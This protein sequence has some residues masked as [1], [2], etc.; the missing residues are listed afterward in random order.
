[1]NA[2]KLSVFENLLWNSIGSFT[3]L[4]CQWLLTLI[5]VRESGNMGNVGDLALAISV[6]NIFYNIACFNVRSYL[7]SDLSGYYKASDYTGFRV[8]S[9]TLSVALCGIYIGVFKYSGEQIVAIFTYMIFKVGEAWVD[10]LHGFEQRQSRM[11]IGGV[12]LF[13]RGLLSVISFYITLKITQNLIWSIAIM[14]LTTYA[15]IVLYDMRKIKQF[16]VVRI[17]IQPATIKKMFF[18]FLPLTVGGFCSSLGANLPRQVL[19]L[20]LGKESLGIYSTVATPAV[21]VQV[22]A[23]YIFNPVLTEFAWLYQQGEKKKFLKLAGKISLVLVLL[24]LVSIVGSIFLGKWGLIL[25]YGKY[26]G[27]YSYLLLPVIIFTCLNAYVW[28]LWNLLIILRALK[29]LLIISFVGLASC[30][31]SMIPMIFF[32]GMNGVSYSLIIYS[33]VMI[34]LMLLLMLKILKN[35]VKTV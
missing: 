34:L 3:Y 27:E 10:L 30:V 5:V 21:I 35:G 2:K 7:I 17:S 8:F 31:V 13:I 15:F 28:F 25:L 26:I 11:D 24:S 18:E 20:K 22:A 29:K 16:E 14:S 19:E 23:S 6:T 4:V 12:S 33:I 1:M 9:C 32:L